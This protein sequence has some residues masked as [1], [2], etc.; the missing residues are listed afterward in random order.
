MGLLI[1][2][3]VAAALWIIGGVWVLLHKAKH[4]PAGA[5]GLALAAGEPIDPIEAGLSWERWLLRTRDGL[6]LPV[7]DIAGEGNGGV[8]V[9]VHDWGEAP[10][11]MLPRASELVPEVSRILIPCLRGHDGV[12]GACGL[13][14][15][16]VEDLRRLLDEIAEEDVRLEGAGLGGWIVEHTRDAPSVNHVMS[17]DP[18]ADSSDGLRRI[19]ASSGFPAFPIATV[20]S[21]FC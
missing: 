9:L 7:W 12:A 6:D 1:L 15:R 20:A 5:A 14:S 2:F 8:V 21:W 4:P 11:S 10:L 17:T 13:G 16:E 3:A 19:L 18:W